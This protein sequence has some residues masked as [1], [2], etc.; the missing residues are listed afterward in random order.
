M[1]LHCLQL[2]FAGFAGR[3]NTKCCNSL[4]IY[5]VNSRNVSLAF[6]PLSHHSC[7]FRWCCLL[8]TLTVHAGHGSI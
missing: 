5:F 8:L 4:F 2:I 1:A 3:D 7:F 6:E